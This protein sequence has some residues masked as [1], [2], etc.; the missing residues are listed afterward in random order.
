MVEI[1]GRIVIESWDPITL[2]VGQNLVKMLNSRTMIATVTYHVRVMFDAVIVL[3]CCF[4]SGE[5][6]LKKVKILQ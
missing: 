3:R 4:L 5:N 6:E 1:S 2:E